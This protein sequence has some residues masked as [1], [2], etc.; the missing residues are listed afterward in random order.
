MKKLFIPAKLKTEFNEKKFQEISK[1]LPKNIALVYS[2]QFE[3]LAKKIKKQLSGKH[4]ISK[5]S[6]ILGCSSINF[7]KQ[8]NAIL[9]ISSGKFHALSLALTTK[10]QVFLLENNTLT[11]ISKKEI[12]IL[13]KKKKGAYLNFLN[14]KKI[15]ILVS[16]KSGQQRLIRALSLRIQNQDLY[17]FIS[18]NID[19]SE[20]ENFKIDSWINTACPRIEFDS[21]KI[22]NISEI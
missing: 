16:T 6:Q 5:F 13:E 14:S 8:T 20:F 2:I 3:N 12:E 7:S 15:G 11:K 17:Y 19:V 22:V 10:K 4:N 9:L 18:N 21:S 1:K